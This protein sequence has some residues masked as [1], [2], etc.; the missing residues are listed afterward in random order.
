MFLHRFSQKSLVYQ[1]NCFTVNIFSHC[2][3]LFE[4]F[5]LTTLYSS[6]MLWSSVELFQLCFWKGIQHEDWALRTVQLNVHLLSRQTVVLVLIPLSEKSTE[7]F[8]LALNYVKK[9]KVGRADCLSQHLPILYNATEASYWDLN[10]KNQ[11]M[12]THYKGNK[13]LCH[14]PV[15]WQRKKIT[16]Q[17]ALRM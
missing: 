1:K 10:K 7:L 12:E 16:A 3:L 2:Q 17:S 15:L 8:F 14:V 13:L 4:C 6:F 5:I 11:S 9:N